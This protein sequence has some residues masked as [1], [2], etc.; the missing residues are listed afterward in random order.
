MNHAVQQVNFA[1]AEPVFARELSGQMNAALRASGTFQWDG[2]EEVTVRVA[3]HSWYRLRVNSKV[4]MVGPARTAHGHARVDLFRVPM[5]VLRAGTN[6]VVFEVVAYHVPCYSHANDPGFLRAEV[7]M[8]DRVV[9]CTTT[10]INPD[11]AALR[12]TTWGERATRVRRYS[13]QRG[14]TEVYRV[15]EP[16]QPL[17]PVA[18]SGRRL[19]PR[20]VPLPTL[21]VSPACRRYACVHVTPADKGPEPKFW[22]EARDAETVGGLGRQYPRADWA[23]DPQGETWAHAFEV[24]G[25]SELWPVRL[26]GDDVPCVTLRLGGELT[27][28]IRL[29]VRVTATSPMGATARLIVSFDE[30]A[31]ADGG[32]NERRM[33]CV[34]TVAWTLPPGEHVLETMEPYS[35]GVMRVWAAGGV[36]EVLEAGVR[37]LEYPTSGLR[38]LETGDE[39]L[40]RIFNAAVATFCQNSVDLFMDCPS[41]ERAGWLVDSFFTARAAFALTGETTTEA[42][43]LENYLLSPPSPHLPEGQLPMC[44]PADHPD[45][46]FIPQWPLWLVLQLSEFAAR[47]G[48]QSIVRGFAPRVAKLLA[49][50]ERFE[51]DDG[52]LRG[53]PGWSFIEWSKAND[54]QQDLNYPTSMLYAGALE[55]AGR[56]YGRSEW[57]GKAERVRA[58]V[59]AECFDGEWFVDNAVKDERSPRGFTPTRNRT[60]VCQYY[61][62]YFGLATPPSHPTLWQRLVSD[63][64]P[65]RTAFPEIHPANMIWGIMLRLEL[66]RREGLKDQTLRELKGYLLPMADQTGTLWEHCD[67]RA[68]CNHGFASHAAYL[69]WQEVAGGTWRQAERRNA[70]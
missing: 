43:F 14:F 33:E 21:E 39:G 12:L 67:V 34:N 25:E 36:L 50:F 22:W 69:L 60:E 45:G 26:G 66:L 31:S 10:G 18:R 17:T 1:H 68:S 20:R 32:V 52:V 47:G 3:A 55:A 8:G 13:L 6:D 5:R 46:T 58:A 29:V 53:L 11:G 35:L 64:G 28:M 30:L 49:W 4:V 27:G 65:G 42:A 48:E 62:F 38:R 2:H 19:L 56:L 54:L 24:I 16:D 15:G 63:F 70:G 40:D 59:A 9:L 41:R 44:Y 51:R 7:V 61:A 37:R 57:V 23:A